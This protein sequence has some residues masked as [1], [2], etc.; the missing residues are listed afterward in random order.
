MGAVISEF[1][2]WSKFVLKNLNIVKHIPLAECLVVCLGWFR[3]N[4]VCFLLSEVSSIIKEFMAGQ[5]TTSIQSSENFQI[6]DRVTPYCEQY[7]CGYL[8]EYLYQ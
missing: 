1:Y 8:W 5:Q 4:C 2:H 7:V 6:N 3:Q